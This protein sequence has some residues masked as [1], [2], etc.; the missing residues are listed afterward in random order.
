MSNFKSPKF[1][2][3]Q[4]EPEH[5]VRGGYKIERTNVNQIKSFFLKF[6]NNFIFYFKNTLLLNVILLNIISNKLSITI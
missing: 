3:E 6:W 5:L 4:C 1:C 2:T